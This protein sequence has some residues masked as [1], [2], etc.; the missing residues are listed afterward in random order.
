MKKILLATLMLSASFGILGSCSKAAA[1]VAN[2]CDDEAKKVTD[3]ATAF[4]ADPS[5]KAK[6]QAYANALSA[7]FKACPTYYTGTTKKD[8]EDFVANACK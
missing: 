3:A 5:N 7:F 4:S 2:K 1:V 6:C 8:L